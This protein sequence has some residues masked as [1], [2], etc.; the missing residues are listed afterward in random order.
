[1]ATSNVQADEK[2][3]LPSLINT[4]RGPMAIMITMQHLLM[5]IDQD[6][7]KKDEDYQTSHHILRLDSHQSLAGFFI[8]AGILAG[9]SYDLEKTTFSGYMKRK[10]LRYAPLFYISTFLCF[11]AILHPEFNHSA[12]FDLILGNVTRPLV[13]Y[14]PD[15]FQFFNGPLWFLHCLFILQLTTPL[16][17]KAISSLSDKSKWFLISLCTVIPAI[18]AILFV[19]FTD[20]RT[21]T[22][23]SQLNI[24]SNC[25]HFWAGIILFTINREGSSSMPGIIDICVILFVTEILAMS[26]IDPQMFKPASHVAHFCLFPIWIVLMHY[27]IIDI[28]E[29]SISATLLNTL[30]GRFLSEITFE[31]YCLHVPV[32]MNYCL[33]K[34]RA[35]VWANEADWNWGIAYVADYVDLIFIVPLTLLVSWGVHAF[36]EAVKKY[37]KNE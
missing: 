8:I 30:V 25:W 22:Y 5:Y 35:K 7:Y 33:M 18:S 36:I 23:L 13:I 32:W 11:T 1:M 29:K 16:V 19:S 34:D 28:E 20:E 17:L 26:L 37:A 27:I 2:Q 12:W 31:I 24:L 15:H 14:F 4:L 10:L 9:Y 21:V 6:L 3:R